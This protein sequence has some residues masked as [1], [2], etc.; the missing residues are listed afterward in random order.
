MIDKVSN[1]N[2]KT[3]NKKKIQK[4]KQN[5]SFGTTYYKSI[6]NL[7]PEGGSLSLSNKVHPSQEKMF[8]NYLLDRIIVPK[9]KLKHTASLPSSNLD[10]FQFKNGEELTYK[11]INPDGKP[12]LT[13]AG[14]RKGYPES[15][16]IEKDENMNQ[17]SM[18]VFEQIENF[19]RNKI[20]TSNKK[21]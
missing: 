2:L 9:S 14:G 19:L 3:Q 4:C 18:N 16:E 6:T 10:I 13:L 1:Y 7:F 8:L 12:Q 15:I 17:D 11:S 5:L 21:I 20:S